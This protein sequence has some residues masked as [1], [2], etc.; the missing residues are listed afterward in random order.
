MVG[1]VCRLFGG[2]RLAKESEDP[3][4]DAAED[5]EDEGNRPDAG[6]EGHDLR[7]HGADDGPSGGPA[8]HTIAD[9]V[10]REVEHADRSRRPR[11]NERDGDQK[12]SPVIPYDLDAK[13]EQFVHDALSFCKCRT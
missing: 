13:V 5:A 10:D 8:D 6:K 12:G 11:E 2:I 3:T 9:R 4:E 1:T 7:E